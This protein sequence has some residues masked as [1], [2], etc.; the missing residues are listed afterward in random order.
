MLGI[1][2][3]G[4]MPQRQSFRQSGGGI[5]VSRKVSLHEDALAAR[6]A[7]IAR[8]SMAKAPARGLPVAKAMGTP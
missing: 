5:Q 7:A 3:T 8:Q 1:S 2:L 4:I 6:S